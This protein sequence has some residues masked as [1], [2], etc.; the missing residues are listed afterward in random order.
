MATWL[1]VW[2]PSE[3]IALAMSVPQMG[4]ALFPRR[5]SPYR[6]LT[7]GK[8]LG[9]GGSLSVPYSRIMDTA[10]SQEYL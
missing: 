5:H 3:N 8:E 7:D 2:H 1:L 10:T 4:G 6:K 9:V